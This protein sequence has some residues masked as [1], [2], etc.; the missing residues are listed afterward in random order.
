MRRTHPSMSCT[1]ASH[2]PTRLQS[3]EHAQIGQEQRTGTGCNTH[4][5]LLSVSHTPSRTCS[6][7][8]LALWMLVRTPAISDSIR[9]SIS[10]ILSACTDD[11]SRIRPFSRF[12]SSRTPAV[13]RVIS[14][15]RRC[16]SFSTSAIS[17]SFSD[18]IRT[19]SLRSRSWISDLSLAKSTFWVYV[20]RSASS[21][22]TRPRDKLSMLSLMTSMSAVTRTSACSRLIPACS[23]RCTKALVSKCTPRTPNGVAPSMGAHASG[24][25][26]AL[27]G[28][29]G[30]I[31][32]M[33]TSGARTRPRGRS[34]DTLRAVIIAARDQ[35]RR[36]AGYG[37]TRTDY[38]A[39]WLAWS[40][41]K[42]PRLNSTLR[43][44]A[45]SSVG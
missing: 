25:A 14:S 41:S 2:L 4:Q 23:R 27:H 37:Y 31:R 18:F 42:W 7:L 29:T 38:E 33:D 8:N 35:K 21:R 34:I 26:R 45:L 17:L 12:K 40:R 19:K 36:R 1:R 3:T 9:V 39:A 28:R 30:G 44:T 13:V 24:A 16:L 22:R 15:R 32:A 5:V 10:L 43:F 6:T 20:S 11:S